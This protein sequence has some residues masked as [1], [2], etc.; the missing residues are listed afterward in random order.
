MP[1]ATLNNPSGTGYEHFGY[2]VAIS[3]TRAVAGAPWDST[4]AVSAGSAYVFDLSSHVP[5]AP[6]AT[7]RNPNPGANDQFGTA[8]AINGTIVSI[9]APFADS[10]QSGKGAAYVFGPSPYSLWKA[11]EVGDQFAPDNGDPDRDGVSNL[12]EYGLL[13]SPLIPNAAATAAASALYPE[14]SRLR[15]FVPRDPARNDITLEV[16]ATGDL[17]GPWT[18]IASSVRGAPFAGPGYFGGDGATPGVKSVEVRD[19]INIT[20]AP[21]RYLRVRVRR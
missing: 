10:P 12:A 17:P 5:A 15:L 18:T 2:R 8:V 19:T 14:G 11:A 20:D 21:R 6:V 1:V 4:G 16:Q 9:G 7:F 13:R 3:G